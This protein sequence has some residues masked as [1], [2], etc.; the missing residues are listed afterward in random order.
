MYFLVTPRA[1]QEKFG[2]PSCS[3]TESSWSD[4]DLLLSVYV[5]YGK[6][7]IRMIY[8]SET[9]TIYSTQAPFSDRYQYYLMKMSCSH[10][11]FA[12]KGHYFWQYWSE[13]V[14]YYDGSTLHYVDLRYCPISPT[15]LEHVLVAGP[16]WR[17][18]E[19]FSTKLDHTR[20]TENPLSITY[21]SSTRPLIDLP[22][23]YPMSTRSTRSTGPLLDI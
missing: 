9:I 6:R 21:S 13:L 18:F 20:F 8:P 10:F 17:R 14:P 23:R 16:T 2:N 11:S 22:D 7:K 3:S 12:I 15:E 1:Y 5:K 4:Y 19:L